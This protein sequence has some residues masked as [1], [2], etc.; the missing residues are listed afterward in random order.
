MPA[1]DFFVAFTITMT[2]IGALLSTLSMSSNEVGP[3]RQ[4]RRSFLVP[5]LLLEQPR[6][7]VAQIPAP[8]MPGVSARNGNERVSNTMS[9]QYAVEQLVAVKKIRFI[10]TDRRP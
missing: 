5:R 10:L 7:D 4:V 6:H 8:D 3:D 9:V 2:R 1:S